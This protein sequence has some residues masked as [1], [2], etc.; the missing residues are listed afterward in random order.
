MALGKDW[1]LPSANKLDTRQR[2]F[3]KK[4]KIRRVPGGGHTANAIFKKY[5][6][7]HMPSV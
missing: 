2:R 6:F 5:F 3:K 4:K 7:K 1:G